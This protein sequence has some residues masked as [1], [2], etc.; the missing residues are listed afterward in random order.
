[1]ILEYLEPYTTLMLLDLL[2]L[3]SRGPKLDTAVTRVA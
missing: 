3:A 2:R 1:M